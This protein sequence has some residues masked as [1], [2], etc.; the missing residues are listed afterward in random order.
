MIYWSTGELLI[1]DDE[2][3]LRICMDFES[4]FIN[5]SVGVWVWLVDL[6]GIVWLQVVGSYCQVDMTMVFS[7][8]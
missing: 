3:S 5:F 7:C 4:A 8:F 1:A 6:H 2:T